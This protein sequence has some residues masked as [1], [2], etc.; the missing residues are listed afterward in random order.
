MGYNGRM[1]K[2]PALVCRP[3]TPSR[4]KDFAALF[5]PG[6]AC[7]G[8]WCPWVRLPSREYRAVRGTRARRRMKALVD[9]GRVPGLLA[10]EGSRAVGWLALGPREEFRRL[11]TSRALKPVDA[12]PVWS[13]P[14]F[15]VA[16]DARGRG[17][18]T[19]LLKAA[20]DFARRQGA[21]ILEG[22]PVDAR[23]R[24]QAPAFV[25]W[26]LLPA[27]EKAGFREAA[28]RTPGRPVVRRALS[29]RSR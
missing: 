24:R 5:G 10:Y 21:R 23:G 25:W 17:V 2:R 27:F 29:G 8:C 13:A 28:R 18:T 16:R 11:E 1:K 3:L 19:A 9:A 6:G 20:A 12:R 14:C 22:Y 7:G 15:F 4:W 26:G